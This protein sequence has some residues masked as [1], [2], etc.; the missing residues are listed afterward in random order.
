MN[1]NILERNIYCSSY[2]RR[3]RLQDYK[4]LKLWVVRI[5]PII[6]WI[7]VTESSFIIPNIKLSYVLI[8]LRCLYYVRMR[9]SLWILY[10]TMF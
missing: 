7:Y 6:P 9:V 3:T 10:K 1:K 8:R 2:R 4:I 5:D